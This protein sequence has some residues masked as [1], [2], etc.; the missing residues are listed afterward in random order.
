MLTRLLTEVG[1]RRADPPA[2]QQLDIASP[3]YDPTRH[4][5]LTLCTRLPTP[6]PTDRA[7]SALVCPGKM[8]TLGD[9]GAGTGAPQGG[10]RWSLPAYLLRS[11][12]SY[13]FVTLSACTHRSLPRCGTTPLWSASHTPSGYDPLLSTGHASTLANS[14]KAVCILST[15]QRAC[16][17]QASA[18]HHNSVQIE[19]LIGTLGVHILVQEAPGTS[20]QT[21]EIRCSVSPLV[22]LKK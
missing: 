15:G 4:D 22:H 1:A 21:L 17:F 18:R 13:V 3:P 11:L 8:C 16:S 6:H 9:A 12:A 19:C 20:C 2:I 10:K 14:G 5:T 7:V